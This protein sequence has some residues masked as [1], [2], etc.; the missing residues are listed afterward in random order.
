MSKDNRVLLASAA[1]ARASRTNDPAKIRQAK[2]SLAEIKIRR[3]IEETLAAAPPLPAE[4]R[5][6][7][8][9]LLLD[10]GAK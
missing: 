3:A 8:A 6:A 4:A 10:G 2:V 1:V 9:Q 5:E 7:L